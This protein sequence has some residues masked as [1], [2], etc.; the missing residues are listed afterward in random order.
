MIGSSKESI[1]SDSESE[2]TLSRATSER[3]LFLEPLIPY[4]ERLYA[5]R[6]RLAPQG[7]RGAPF[8]LYRFATRIPD[9]NSRVSFPKRLD[10]N[11][12]QAHGDHATTVTRKRA[13]TSAIF[14][15]R[16]SM[17]RDRK[18]GGDIEEKESTRGHFQGMSHS[19]PRNGI[20]EIG[21]MHAYSNRRNANTSRSN[22][23]VRS[24]QRTGITH[25][26]SYGARKYLRF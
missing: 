20:G 16:W 23:S 19:N 13:E 26:A 7:R 2:A 4:T 21:V 8:P 11:R 5:K 6:N 3:E 22:G 1:R 9:E 15:S 10:S 18:K 12:M 14:V 24:S 25:A 17:H